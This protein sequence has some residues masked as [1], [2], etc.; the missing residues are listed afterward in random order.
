VTPTSGDG[1]AERIAMAQAAAGRH[2]DRVT[3]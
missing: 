1:C 2:A 3:E